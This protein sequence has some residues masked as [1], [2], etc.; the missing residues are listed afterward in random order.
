MLSDEYA[1]GFFDGEGCIHI[2]MGRSG[3]AQIRLEVSQKVTYMLELFQEK[4]G[5]KLSGVHLRFDRR[6]EVRNL[7]LALL[8]HLILR[9]R[10][11][12]I[13]LQYV[14][15]PIQMGKRL[16]EEQLVERAKIINDFHEAN[17]ERRK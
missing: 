7:L 14:S 1:A 2:A 4:Y 16:I 15:L 5:G 17:Y 8:P 11:A 10:E 3:I 12:E 9:R 6:D 13:A